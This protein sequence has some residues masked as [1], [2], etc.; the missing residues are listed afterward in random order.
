MTRWDRMLSTILSLFLAAVPCNASAQAVEPRKVDPEKVDPRAAKP[1]C[2]AN[3]VQRIQGHNKEALEKLSRNETEPARLALQKAIAEAERAKCRHHPDLGRSFLLL[4]VTYFR[5]GPL[6]SKRKAWERALQIAPWIK[7]PAVLSSLP[8]VKDFKAARIHLLRKIRAA[9]EALCTETVLLRIETLDNEAFTNMMVED[10]KTARRKIDL[11]LAAGR[12]HFCMR[13][14]RMA[15]TFLILGFLEHLAEQKEKMM[16]AW[17]IAL[18]LDPNVS[19]NWSSMSYELKTH[20]MMVRQSILEKWSHRRA[21]SASPPEVQKTGCRTDLDCK[22]ELVCRTGRCILPM[23]VEQ[24]K[25][26][27]TSA[28]KKRFSDKGTVEIGGVVGLM[29]D[30]IKLKGDEGTAKSSRLAVDLDFYFGYFPARRFVL[31]LVLGFP[32]NKTKAEVMGVTSKSNG[33]DVDVMFAPGM[34]WPLGSRSVFFMDG[35]FGMGFQTMKMDLTETSLTMGIIGGELGL[36]FLLARYCLLR[37]GVRPT[38][39]FGKAK[40]NNGSS[41][42]KMDLSGGE[43]LRRCVMFRRVAPY[44]T[45]PNDF[46]HNPS[47]GVFLC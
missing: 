39:R 5:T 31:G 6:E 22:G 26:G 44:G 21:A 27:P 32:I 34:A 2:D 43:I 46:S 7:L 8:L 40:V 13:K 23:R 12:K 25:R 28:R 33:F 16:R 38:Y 18:W 15:K 36:K 3:L 45:K 30:S 10:T 35:L 37:M 42:T 41:S 20:F 29:W 11:A 19:L 1:V 17:R 4:G 9:K 47:F 14:K 24:E